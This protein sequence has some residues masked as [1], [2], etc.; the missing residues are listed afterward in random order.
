MYI[1]D[2]VDDFNEKNEPLEEL[3]RQ[4]AKEFPEYS[5]TEQKEL[6]LKIFEDRDKRKK[7]K[8]YVDPL[9]API[10]SIEEDEEPE[11]PKVE[12]KHSNDRGLRNILSGGTN[13][14]K[15]LPILSA[16]EALNVDIPK[17]REDF[18]NHYISLGKEVK[19]EIQARRFDEDEELSDE[20]E[21]VI[22]TKKEVLERTQMDITMSAQ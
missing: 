21:F 6:A 18:I 9:N 15:D 4:I 22:K 3:E 5:R 16:V 10:I 17:N 7:K 20:E 12:E 14:R 13:A 8:Q 19:T 11:E 2:E 1:S